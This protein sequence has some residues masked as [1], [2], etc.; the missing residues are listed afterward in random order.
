[1]NNKFFKYFGIC[2]VSAIV[3]FSAYGDEA[4]ETASGVVAS[5]AVVAERTD[6]AATKARIDELNAAPDDALADELN[7][8]Q[9]LYRRDCVKQVSGRRSVGGQISRIAG[10]TATAAVPSSGPAPVV[11][12][13]VK[14]PLEEFNDG[15][16]ALCEKLNTAIAAA[17]DNKAD[18]QKVYDE[19]CVDAPAVV[20]S[21]EEIAA[22]RAQGLCPD[23][24]GPNK[25]GC[26]DGERFTD[27][28]NLEFMC[29]ANDGAGPC[30]APLK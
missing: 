12:V 30:V 5:A 9:A 13:T 1:M 16:D 11:A 20:I 26:C 27:K 15:L 7:S 18:M 10:G 8:L 22:R 29:C 4:G 6:C 23:G 14:T 28:G 25:F 17:S 24:L 3:A 21:E 2:A 19:K